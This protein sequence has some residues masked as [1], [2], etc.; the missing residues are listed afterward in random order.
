MFLVF[1]KRQNG[2]VFT[3]PSVLF[4]SAILVPLAA[5]QCYLFGFFLDYE[6]FLYFLALPVIVCIGLIIVKAS[7][8]IPIGLPKSE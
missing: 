8:I 1:S 6:R 3:L 2:K 7:E 4:A 5:A